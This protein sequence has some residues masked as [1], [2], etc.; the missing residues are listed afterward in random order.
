MKRLVKEDL[1]KTIYGLRDL[2]T[3]L[4]GMII[5]FIF[6]FCMERGE[7]VRT[8]NTYK[9]Q[10][11]TIESEL[12]AAEFDRDTYKATLDDFK[13]ENLELYKNYT[14]MCEF[15]Q[16]SSML[17]PV[18]LHLVFLEYGDMCYYDAYHN[19]ALYYMNENGILIPLY[20]E[21]GSIRTFDI[22]EK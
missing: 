6:L 15:W 8:E 5:V 4:I 19:N 10:I 16:H 7:R 11:A 21:D 2:R 20:S 17:N 14:E 22:K 1:I 3:F 9:E 12:A 18:D 13:E